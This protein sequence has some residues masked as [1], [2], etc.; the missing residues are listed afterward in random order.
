M[1]KRE[2][3]FAVPCTAMM[4]DGIFRGAILGTM[5]G[6]VTDLQWL[7]SLIA[8]PQ[9]TSSRIVRRLNA[10]GRSAAGFAMFIGAYSGGSCLGEKLTGQSRDHWIPA[11]IGGFFGGAI[12]S[13]RS[14]NIALCAG[15]GSTPGVF[16]GMVRYLQT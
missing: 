2:S 11:F 16:A 12:F 4:A 14:R 7:E 10:V 15:I 3:T 1:M 6:S 8:E 13:V 9:V 5:W